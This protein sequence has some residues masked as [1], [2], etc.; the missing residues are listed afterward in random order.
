MVCARTPWV[1]RMSSPSAVTSPTKWRWQ[2]ARGTHGSQRPRCHAWRRRQTR[3]AQTCHTWYER[4]STSSM[5]GRSC[6]TPPS[7]CLSEPWCGS[8]C[9][10]HPSGPQLS[11]MIIRP[12]RE[13]LVPYSAPKWSWMRSSTG[14]PHLRRRVGGAHAHPSC[15]QQD[16]N[17]GKMLGSVGRLP[18]RGA[19]LAYR[20]REPTNRCRGWGCSRPCTTST[21]ACRRTSSS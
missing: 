6:D 18:R 11:A 4:E 15:S 3:R 12:C 5:R 10:R 8:L 14:N 2:N 20:Q 19:A 16:R 9:R 1:W 17:T 7:T 13:R 21:C